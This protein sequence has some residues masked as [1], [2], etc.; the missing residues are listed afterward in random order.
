MRGRTTRLWNRPRGAFLALMVACATAAPLTGC[1]SGGDP[2]PRQATDATAPTTQDGQE[3][4]QQKQERE[5]REKEKREREKEKEKEKDNGSFNRAGRLS[6]DF[7]GVFPF[8]YEKEVKNPSSETYV[9]TIEVVDCSPDGKHPPI[10]PP[11]QT[12]TVPPKG[13]VTASFNFLQ[14]DVTSNESRILCVTLRNEGGVADEDKDTVPSQVSTTGD[15]TTGDT[16]TGDTTTG[17]TTTGDTTTGDTTTGD[18]TGQT[19]GDTTTG[20]TTTGDTTTGDT[21][22][23]DTTTGQTTGDTT[24]GG[25][26]ETGGSGGNG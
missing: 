21:T 4:D 3:T 19:T 13:N 17:D 20:D 11:S 12:V 24:T 10:T 8:G 15:T 2:D 7:T 26:S 25:T 9:G 5:K 14:G 6:D 1:S 18:T 22:T 16:T 23:G